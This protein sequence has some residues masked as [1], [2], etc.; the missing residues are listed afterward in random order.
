M[1]GDL[2]VIGDMLKA[3]HLAGQAINITQ[4]TAAHAMSYKLTSL[5][6]VSHGHAVALC[7]TG[8]WPYML[9]HPEACC[10][11]RGIA[12]LECAYAAIARC[13]GVDSAEEAARRFISLYDGA[14]LSCPTVSDEQLAV[15]VHAVN[16]TRL[17]NHPIALSEQAIEAIYRA[18]LHR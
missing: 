7:M 6:G 13:F 4:T 1:A 15:L 5:F 3:A 17:K 11:P 12:A 16:P 10:D 8:V 9:A 14:A 18:I 2:T